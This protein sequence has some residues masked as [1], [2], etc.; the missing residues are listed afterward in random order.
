[1]E[2][3]LTGI[4]LRDVLVDAKYKP[5]KIREIPKAL[6]KYGVDVDVTTIQRYINA[7]KKGMLGYTLKCKREDRVDRY[8]LEKDR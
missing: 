3:R 2:A 5:I 8:W 7:M 1:M 4:Y 6:K